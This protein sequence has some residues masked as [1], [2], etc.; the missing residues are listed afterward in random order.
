MKSIEQIWESLYDY[1]G[2]SESCMKT[3]GCGEQEIIDLESLIKIQLPIA[4]KNSLK[5]CNYKPIN[6]KEV[7]NSCCL[8]TGGAGELL[9]VREIAET[10]NEMITYRGD[11]GFDIIYGKLEA[12]NYSWLLHWIPIYDYNG[13]EFLAIDAYSYKILYID[14]EFSTLAFV[15]N[16]YEELLNYIHDD[17]IKN[18]KFNFIG[19]KKS[20]LL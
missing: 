11:S 19:Y 4:F 8:L 6:R 17:I 12:P 9:T 20:F 15:T 5:L 1:W 10:Y 16:N 14:L 7:L 13:N 18:G 2:K 3:L